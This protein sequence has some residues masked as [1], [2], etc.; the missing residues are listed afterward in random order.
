MLSSKEAKSFESIKGWINLR[1][2]AG[3]VMEIWPAAPTPFPAS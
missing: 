1:S 3:V 2:L